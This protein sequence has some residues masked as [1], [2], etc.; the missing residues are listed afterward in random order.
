[1]AQVIRQVMNNMTVRLSWGLVLVTFTAMVLLACGIGLYALHHGA[2]IVQN[3]DAA[4][5]QQA[6][7]TFA[8]QI[9]WVLLGVVMV[10]IATVII[11]VWGWR[12]MCCARWTIWWATLSAWQRAT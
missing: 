8:A 9:R 3:S 7:T 11:V 2:N 4:S 10:T 12:P 5:Q 1:M 6:F